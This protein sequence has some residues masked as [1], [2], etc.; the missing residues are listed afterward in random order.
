[1][2]LKFELIRILVLGRYVVKEDN[3][4]S[5]VAEIKQ[6]TWAESDATHAVLK[7]VAPLR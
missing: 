2:F 7:S 1:M 4:Y 3:S 5:F 6:K